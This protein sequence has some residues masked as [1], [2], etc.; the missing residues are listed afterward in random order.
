MK[1]SYYFVIVLE[2]HILIQMNTPSFKES[3]L[4]ATSAAWDEK[5]A[6]V[7]ITISVSLSFIGWYT[8]WFSVGGWA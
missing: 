3:W 6:A 1:D 5:N 4:S 8:G 7:F 2:S